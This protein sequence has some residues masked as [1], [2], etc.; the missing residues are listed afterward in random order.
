MLKW[1]PVFSVDHEFGFA[2][3]VT[4]DEQQWWKEFPAFAKFVFTIPERQL[5]CPPGNSPL[6]QH[7]TK[8]NLFP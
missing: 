2:I 6:P 8:S 5:P 7:S 3:F 4:G 1:L